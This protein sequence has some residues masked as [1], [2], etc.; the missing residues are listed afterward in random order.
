MQRQVFFERRHH[1]HPR[2]SIPRGSCSR[3]SGRQ[4]VPQGG[5]SWWMLD[6]TAPCFLILRS[7]S[8]F[9]R[10]HLI[11]PPRILPIEATCERVRAEGDDP[12]VSRS[13][14]GQKGSIGLV[15]FPI[16][17]VSVDPHVRRSTA[18]VDMAP[19]SHTGQLRSE[20][21]RSCQDGKQYH[22]AQRK[23]RHTCSTRMCTW[24]CLPV[25]LGCRFLGAPC[26]HRGPRQRKRYLV[27]PAAGARGAAGVGVLVRERAPFAP[28][29]PSQRPG[30]IF[31]KVKLSAE[32]WVAGSSVRNLVLCI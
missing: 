23:Q 15:S 2:M 32:V 6:V 8:V 12:A 24:S 7:C 29:R 10:H 25:R 22:N 20:I 4:L 16:F 5:R 27:V 18:R 17:R 14:K 3:L 26:G 9:R 19:T 28:M 31:C 1:R 11:I 21:V 13:V 30:E